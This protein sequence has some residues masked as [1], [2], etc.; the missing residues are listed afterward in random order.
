MLPTPSLVM[1]TRED[2]T[3][4]LMAPFWFPNLLLVLLPTSSLKVSLGAWPPL[5][6]LFGLSF[7]LCICPIFPGSLRCLRFR[8]KPEKAKTRSPR[9]EWREREVLMEPGSNFPQTDC[10]LGTLRS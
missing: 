10:S 4:K 9:V 6:L 7:S 8:V 1:G 5:M 3:Q 2:Q